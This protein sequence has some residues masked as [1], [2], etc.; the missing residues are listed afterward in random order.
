MS[1]RM[2]LKSGW[3]NPPALPGL[4]HPNEKTPAHSLRRDTISRSADAV[5]KKPLQEYLTLRTGR[6]GWRRWQWAKRSAPLCLEKAP[7]R[8]ACAEPLI[9]KESIAT[10]ARRA[11]PQSSL[12]VG[13]YPG[14]GGKPLSKAAAKELVSPAVEAYQ[15]RNERDSPRDVCT[16]KLA[17]LRPRMC[18]GQNS[19]R[20][21]NA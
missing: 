15:T 4:H 19:R 17:R 1:H 20:L 16:R 10:I 18:G 6:Q 14:P 7:G 8:D 3:F 9:C 21:G 11:T 5:L 2:F 13:R 12:L